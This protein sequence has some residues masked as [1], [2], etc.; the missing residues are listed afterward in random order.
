MS[1]LNNDVNGIEMVFSGTVIRIVRNFS[2]LVFITV[3]LISMNWKLSILALFIV[4]MFVAP[5]RRV[6]RTRWRIAAQTQAKLAELSSII[7]ETLNVSG[8]MLVKISTRERDEYKKFSQI[9]REISRLQI[10]ESVAGRWF[11]MVIQ[12][13]THLGPV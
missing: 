5:T 6:G 1:R 8:A 10:R 11:R 4:P 9:N 7:Q 12:I 3:T 13:F 2:T